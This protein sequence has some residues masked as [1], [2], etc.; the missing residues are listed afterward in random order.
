M[1][2][3]AAVTGKIT[4]LE[5]TMRNQLDALRKSVND[6][7]DQRLSV[8]SEASEAAKSGTQRMDRDLAAIKAQ[9][10]QLASG[11][12]TL[13]ADNERES[14]T[15][16][17]TEDGLNRLKSEMDA[18][19]SVFAKPEDVAA[20]VTPLSGKL[21]ALQSDVQSVVKSE[22]SRK[23]TAERIVLSLELAS[24]KRAIDRGRGFEP[25]LVQARKLAGGAVDLAPLDRFADTG[26]PTLAQLRQDFKQVAFKLIDAGEEPAQGSIVDRLLAGAK[27]VVRVRKISHSASDTS[28]EA[29][30]GRMETALNEDRLGDVLQEAK[31][32]P[33]PAQEAAQEFLAKVEARHAVDRALNS[34]EAQ[35]KASLVAP[36]GPAGAAKE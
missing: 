16:K 25:E 14:A 2:Q 35:L 12:D 11:L 5:S 17:A 1:P 33:P 7:I 3:L 24:L 36:A 6:E 9:Y 34:V 32:L 29:V 8:A 31:A 23:A 20:A 30:V 13:N 15:L 21:A 28:V 19:L 4:D 10:A 26:V 18:R 22:E 27:S